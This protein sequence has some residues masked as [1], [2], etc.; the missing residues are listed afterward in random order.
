MYLVEETDA[1]RYSYLEHFSDPFL[2]TRIEPLFQYYMY[3]YKILYIS[4]SIATIIT[5]ITIYS[6]L[7]VIWFENVNIRRFESFII[8]NGIIF[9]VFNYYIGTSIRMGLAMSLALYFFYKINNGNNSKIIYVLMI[10]TIF[11][12]YG[13]VLF[14]LIFL[15]KLFF[16]KNN[17]TFFNIAV[18][19]LMS[20]VVVLS[21][22]TIISFMEINSYYSMYLDGFG[23]TER[24]IPFTMLL[25][26]I[27]LIVLMILKKNDFYSSLVL[28]GFPFLIVQFKF[29]MAFIGKML[30]PFLFI[31]LVYLFNQYYKKIFV[32]ID[33]SLRFIV[34]IVFNSVSLLY[35]LNM[36]NYAFFK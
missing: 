27:C 26:I 29:N 13:I 33:S 22:N 24:I 15:F 8:F 6:L 36:Y 10:S 32:R 9:S 35:A 19:F 28:Y 1:D 31:S 17:K 18:V 5:I 4:P 7:A 16:I 25:F 34:L 12:H 14:V 23:A 30:M 3:L 11:I 2:N 20:I 21:L